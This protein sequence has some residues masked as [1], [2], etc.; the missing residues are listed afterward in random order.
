[1]KNS[2]SI[3]IIS[4]ARKN[5]Q[6]T[7][8]CLTSLKGQNIHEIIVVESDHETYYPTATTIHPKKDIEFNYNKFL[9]IGAKVATGYYIAFC[10]NDLIFNNGWWQRLYN[11]MQ[12]HESNSSSPLCPNT[13]KEYGFTIS[14]NVYLGHQ[15]RKYVAGW[16]LVLNRLWYLRMGGFDERFSFWCADNSYGKQLEQHKEK[17]ILDCGSIVHH[18]Q[19]ATLNKLDDKTADDY[20]RKQV[21]KYNNTF[22]E[23]LFNL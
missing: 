16:C 4:D 17:H 1:M 9:N 6:V 23:K 22:N 14:D 15:I 21:I 18:V 5:K 20:T 8:D 7:L 2:I 11:S 12:K 13:G 19:S 10:N 3:V